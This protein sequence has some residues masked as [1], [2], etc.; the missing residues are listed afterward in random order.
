MYYAFDQY[1]HF[2][3]KELEKIALSF[4]KNIRKFMFNKKMDELTK[5]PELALITHTLV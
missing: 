2:G 5:S 3:K 4:F 1:T